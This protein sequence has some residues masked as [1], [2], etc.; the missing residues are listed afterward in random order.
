MVIGPCNRIAIAQEARFVDRNQRTRP[1][2]LTEDRQ[3]LLNRWATW[4]ALA[5][6]TSRVAAPL[7][8]RKELLPIH[9][10]DKLFEFPSILQNP[11]CVVAGDGV[12]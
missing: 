11:F 3:L 10:I 12:A 4:I 9:R 2:P 7:G 1:S 6:N 5:R 8:H